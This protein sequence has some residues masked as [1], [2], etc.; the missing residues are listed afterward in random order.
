MAEEASLSSV[1][2]RHLM[3]LQMMHKNLAVISIETQLIQQ[4][5]ALKHNGECRDLSE[6]TEQPIGSQSVHLH[7]AQQ[8][9]VSGTDEKMLEMQRRMEELQTQL[10]LE[11]REREA[12]QEQ[13]MECKERGIAI[14][15]EMHGVT[16][17]YE[18]FQQALDKIVDAC[19]KQKMAMKTARSVGTTWLKLVREKRCAVSEQAVADSARPKFSRSKT[20]ELEKKTEELNE[21]KH[22]IEKAKME[23]EAAIEVFDDEI[24][25]M[26]NRVAE[27]E[28]QLHQASGDSR[29]ERERLQR[30]VSFLQE[31]VKHEREARSRLQIE[32]EVNRDQ[33]AYVK[34]GARPAVAGIGVPGCNT[35]LE[36]VSLA[37]VPVIQVQSARAAHVCQQVEPVKLRAVEKYCTPP[38]QS[39]S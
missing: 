7:G 10:E 18:P 8:E 17:L 37:A 23:R 15:D 20:A 21:V 22:E 29:A 14:A 36:G 34:P 24:V 38:A 39:V 26:R 9:E 5:M 32:Q 25:V 27:L 3:E 1:C 12:L 6:D 11:K 19:V 30:C 28:Q 4:Q 31:Q 2:K 13:L 33:Q 16:E 35:K